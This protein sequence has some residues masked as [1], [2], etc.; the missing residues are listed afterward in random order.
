MFAALTS[1][2]VAPTTRAMIRSRSHRGGRVVTCS[3]NW[4]LDRDGCGAARSEDV[5]SKHK[6]STNKISSCLAVP[7]DVNA[8]VKTN[9]GTLEFDKEKLTFEVNESRAD[10][11]VVQSL[12]G[13]TLLDGKKLGKGKKTR[14]HAGQKIRV[15]DEEFVVYR[16]THA[17]A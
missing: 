12:S 2:R 4:I 8:L 5:G 9:K 16:N 11:L 7:I 14:V 1:T 17:H 10:E 15:D 13:T 3:T 6:K